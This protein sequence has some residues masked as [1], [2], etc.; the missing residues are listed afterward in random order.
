MTSA[1]ALSLP[2]SFN[3]LLVAFS[4]I[5][6]IATPWLALD[7]AGRVSA[8]RGR[9]RALWVAGGAIA[10][11]IG[12]TAFDLCGIAVTRLPA[13]VRYEWPLLLLALITG[14]L[15]SSLLLYSAR[16]R[17]TD[18]MQ[19]SI[20]SVIV[21]LGIAAQHYI[22]LA[23]MRLSAR[24]RFNSLFAAVSV[25]PA[26]ASSWLMLSFATNPQRDNPDRASNRIQTSLLAGLG[27]LAMHYA[28]LTSA[29]YGFS[30]VAAGFSHTV[31]ISPAEALAISLLALALLGVAS[32]AV[33]VDRRF[34]A[35]ALKLA[36]AEA[37]VALSEAGRQAALS[38]VA[39]TIVHE[40]KQPL[41]VVV[42]EIS[43]SLRWLG[44][45]P[46]DL[47]EAS[48]SLARAIRNANRTSDE[49]G[50]IGALVRRM[51]PPMTALDVEE[52]IL[53]ALFLAR[54]TIVEC[55][56]I[57]KTDLAPDAPMAAGDR[58]QIQQLLLSLILNAAEAMSTVNGQPRELSIRLSANA[59][60]ILVQV[61]DSGRGLEPEQ[62]PDIFDSFFSTRPH[63]V[64]TGLAL[65]RS[66][67]QTH[68]GR[69][70]A[71]P[72]SPSGTIFQFT[73]RKAEKH[74][75]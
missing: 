35:Q 23:S 6:A 34:R 51:P 54:S 13:A 45:K 2:T 55:G 27:F 63:G 4:A 7:C 75:G 40:I 9:Q 28:A 50:R 17:Q 74:N 60:E 22:G 33:A 31:D 56:I 19:T 53:E 62:S 5:L 11:G 43:A 41:A 49:A 52:I 25:L 70:W 47:I 3:Y 59:W 8:G 48:E 38:E 57:V 16:A 30:G 14:I 44:H 69:L 20:I 24:I 67:V 72:A 71:A 58:I 65:C 68:G 42:T 73:L 61:Q 37:S 26:I 36:W 66:I 10:I 46:P 12:T 21:G 39:A 29:T 64:G 18:R 1:N 32:C 15:S